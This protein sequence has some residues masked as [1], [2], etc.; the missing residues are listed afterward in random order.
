MSQLRNQ[1]QELFQKLGEKGV[2]EKLSRFGS[3]KKAAAKQFLEEL[4]RNQ[5]HDDR[6]RFE[7]FQSEQLEV[8]RSAAF[9]AWTSA[10]EAKTANAIA[11]IALAA[12]IVAIAISIAGWFLD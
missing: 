3:K 6:A 5:E 8:S 7:A 11:K 4:E 12:A 10:E 1:Y 2:R 9:A